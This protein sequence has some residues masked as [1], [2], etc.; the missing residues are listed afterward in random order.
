M[1]ILDEEDF[2]HAPK[3]GNSLKEFLAKTDKIPEN[4]IIGRLLLLSPEEVEKIYEESVV[5]LKKDMVDED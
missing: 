3:F 1:K 2:I 4:N 5:E